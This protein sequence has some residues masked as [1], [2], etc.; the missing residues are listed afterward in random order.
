[1]G[2]RNQRFEVR[3]RKPED[4][5]HP[6]VARLAF[7]DPAAALLLAAVVVH[8]KRK[9]PAG[10]EHAHEFAGSRYLVVAWLEML[11]RIG[12]NHRVKIAVWIIEMTDI[13]LREGGAHAE[14]S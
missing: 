13:T 1:V 2:L 6:R 12:A 14:R 8:R 3:E 5:V 11:K 4:V 7:L 10:L 9:L